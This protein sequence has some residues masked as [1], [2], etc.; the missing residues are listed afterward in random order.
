MCTLRRVP[1]AGVEE[2]ARIE[3]SVVVQQ[4]RF[5]GVQMTNVMFRR[6]FSTP[7]VQDLPHCVL[8]FHCVMAF[9]HDVILM[10]DLTE[11]VPV[12]ELVEK[13]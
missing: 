8:Y 11:E 7:P 6:I 10:K 2:I 4:C 13:P 1:D 9:L 5:R 12:I 3:A